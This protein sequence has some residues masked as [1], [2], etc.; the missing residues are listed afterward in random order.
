MTVSSTM[1]KNAAINF[2]SFRGYKKYAAQTAYGQSKL[3]NVLFA[4][5]LAE[6][7]KGTGVTSNVLHPGGVRTGI[8]RDLPWLVRKIIDLMFISPEAGAKTTIMLASDAA[9]EDVTGRYYDQGKQA[10]CSPRANDADLRQR[11]WRLSETMVGLGS[12]NPVA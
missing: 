11:L 1:H 7:L 8:T 2:D 12:T 10:D 4:V 6:R 5:E 3:A 9:L